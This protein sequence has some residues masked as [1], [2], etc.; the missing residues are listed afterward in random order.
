MADRWHEI[1]TTVYE[2][3]FDA[4]LQY[5]AAVIAV[6]AVTGGAVF[7]ALGREHITR[8]LHNIKTYSHG[9]ALYILHR[10][11]KMSQAKRDKFLDDVAME[12][13][14]DRFENMALKGEITYAD[15]SRAYRRLGVKLELYE[16]IPI[17][18]ATAVKE[19]IKARLMRKRTT[20]IPNG[21]KTMLDGLLSS[22][23]TTA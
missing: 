22:R 8:M 2:L 13:I 16:L 9:S 20:A 18:S 21:K 23:N 17:R 19:G 11:N 3:G 15:K 12:A 6:M 4:W 14:T 5:Y 7:A 1:G 10:G